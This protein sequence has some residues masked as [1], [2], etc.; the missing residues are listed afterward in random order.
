ML[1]GAAGAF[2]VQVF[3][4]KIV[5]KK[6]LNLKS[7]DLDF[8]ADDEEE[9]EDDDDGSDVDGQGTAGQNLFFFP[10]ASLFRGYHS[11]RAQRPRLSSLCPLTPCAASLPFALP[12][13]CGCDDDGGGARRPAED[14]AQITGKVI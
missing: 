5:L 7:K 6:W 14:G 3:W 1:I 2:S 10:D 12:E 9:E 13:N 8:G 11:F 4:P